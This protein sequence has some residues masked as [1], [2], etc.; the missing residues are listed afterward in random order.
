MAYGGTDVSEL[1]DRDL[2]IGTLLSLLQDDAKNQASYL[3][4]YE[5]L[6]QPGA[7]RG[8][9]ARHASRRSIRSAD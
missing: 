3:T 2:Q 8:A 7:I 6:A 9:S 5:G 4:W 1:P